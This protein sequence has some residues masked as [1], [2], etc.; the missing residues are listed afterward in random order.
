MYNRRLQGASKVVFKSPLHEQEGAEGISELRSFINVLA[1][2]YRERGFFQ[3]PFLLPKENI[4]QRSICSLS[5]G[6]EQN[7]KESE[8]F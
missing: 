4:R 2:Y 7:R 8:N 6:H 5:A 3:V 1:K